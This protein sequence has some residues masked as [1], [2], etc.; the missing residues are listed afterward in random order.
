[1]SLQ[2]AVDEYLARDDGFVF[3][4]SIRLGFRPEESDTFEKAL[5][6]YELIVRKARASWTEQCFNNL[7]KYYTVNHHATFRVCTWNVNGE[8]PQGSL[9]DW[10]ISPATKDDMIVVG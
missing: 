3:G 6:T 4:N 5:S 8:M 9:A 1:M 7:R 2:T 10:L